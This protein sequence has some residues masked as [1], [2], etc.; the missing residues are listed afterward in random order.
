MPQTTAAASVPPMPRATTLAVVFAIATIAA[1][2]SGSGTAEIEVEQQDGR[3]SATGTAEIEVEQQDAQP[4]AAKKRLIPK[5]LTQ[6]GDPERAAN[7]DVSTDVRE[8]TVRRLSDWLVPATE[9]YIIW[10]AEEFVDFNTAEADILEAAD[11]SLNNDTPESRHWLTSDHVRGTGVMAGV[12]FDDVDDGILSEGD[13][14]IADSSTFLIFRQKYTVANEYHI[15][16]WNEGPFDD[17]G[18]KLA[19]YW[20]VIPEMDCLSRFIFGTEKY[21]SGGEIEAWYIYLD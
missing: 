15:N 11:Y 18:S 10:G 9:E 4:W 12:F 17:G 20:L 5:K 13:A 21:V 7:C 1:S 16:E 3:I 2:C 8:Y 19:H 6:G 14:S